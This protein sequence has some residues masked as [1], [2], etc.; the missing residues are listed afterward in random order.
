MGHLKGGHWK[1]VITVKF[2]LDMSVLTAPSKAIPQGK[3]L[4]GRESAVG[5]GKAP[6]RRHRVLKVT[7][8]R[9][10][11]LRCSGLGLPQK[12]IRICSNKRAGRFFFCGRLVFT[13]GW[14]LLVTKI[15]LVFFSHG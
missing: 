13:Y 12:P 9:C 8:C 6:S 14:S 11:R 15:G 4:L 3:R 10:A 1:W 7:I 2:S 5:T